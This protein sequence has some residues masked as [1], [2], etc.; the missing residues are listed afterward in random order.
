MS[1][2]NNHQSVQPS[3][4]KPQLQST[5]QQTNSK[6]VTLP[7]PNDTGMFSKSAKPKDR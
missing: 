2:G 7:S 5:S 1:K 4:P 3:A 6:S